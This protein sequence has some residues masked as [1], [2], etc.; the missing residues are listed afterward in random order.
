MEAWLSGKE[1]NSLPRPLDGECNLFRQINNDMFPFSTPGELIGAR[2]I[3]QKKLAHDWKLDIEPHPDLFPTP[4]QHA[5][6]LW[7]YVSRTLARREKLDL[8]I[9]AFSWGTVCTGIHFNK[10]SKFSWKHKMCRGCCSL[11]IYVGTVSTAWN[12]NDANAASKP[13]NSCSLIFLDSLV[14]SVPHRQ[15]WVLAFSL[16]LCN[17]QPPF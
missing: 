12:Q 1:I 8:P 17:N 6:S 16:L 11:W 15:L 10:S 14:T 4:C 9:E 7:G 5:V 13:A 2:S 3:W